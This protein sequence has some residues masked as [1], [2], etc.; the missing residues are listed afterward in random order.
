MAD[1]DAELRARIV[2][3]GPGERPP[4]LLA[5]V[6]LSVLVAVANLVLWA[7]GWEVRGQ[8]L[9][10]AAAIAPALLFAILA[11]GL[12]RG[13]LLAIAGMQVVLALTALSATGALLVASDLASAL[14][15]AAVVV[16]CGVLFWPLIRL[17]ARAGLRDRVEHHG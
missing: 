13:R 6:V 1:R 7:S 8:E 12:W 15:S 14:L 4:A 10:G 17:N 2:P 5:G 3:L 9:N 11:V 16:V